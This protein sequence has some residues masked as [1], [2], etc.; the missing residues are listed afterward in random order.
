MELALDTL[1]GVL[2][3]VGAEDPGSPDEAVAFVRQSQPSFAP[4]LYSAWERDG[5]ELNPSLRYDLDLQRGRLASYLELTDKLRDPIPGALPLKGFEIAD[6]YPDGLVRYMND[7]DYFVADEAELWRGAAALAGWGWE[8]WQATFARAED[9]ALRIL[10]SMRR[11]HE[12]PYCFPYGVELMNYLSLGDLGGVPVWPSLPD[13]WREPALKNVLMLLYERLEQP[14]RARDL[15]DAALLLDALPATAW[16][17]LLP[18]ISALRL[19]PEYA[20]L[21]RLLARTPLPPAPAPPRGAVLAARAARGRATAATWV[22]PVD[23]GL[24]HLQRRLLYRGQRPPER[25][26]WTALSARLPADRALAAG[27]VVFGVPVDERPRGDRAVLGS[28]RGATW[29]DTPVGRFLLAAGDEVAEDLL[30]AL[31]V[32]QP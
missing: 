24:R 11:P 25:A 2:E 3:S 1:E 4:T 15:V 27:M 30:D 28:A 29:A 23:G 20:E 17:R 26:A 19:W 9:G 21:A 7:L 6:T 22:S 8:A 10:V 14:Y 5:R 16:S 13:R 18:A 12:D 31:P 32:D